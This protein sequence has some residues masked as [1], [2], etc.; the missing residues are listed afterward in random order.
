[1]D[2]FYHFQSILE[3]G[4]WLEQN[5]QHEH[6]HQHRIGRKS[7]EVKRCSVIGVNETGSRVMRTKSK[8]VT[9]H[10]LK[11]YKFLKRYI[12]YKILLL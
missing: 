5:S 2:I 6:N 1:M 11:T 12:G 10:T 9:F 7:K 4:Q 3:T 8:F